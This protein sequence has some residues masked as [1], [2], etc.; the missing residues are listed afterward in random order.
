MK[1][2]INFK[3]WDGET[4]SQKETGEAGWKYMKLGH[5]GDQLL[6]DKEY[7]LLEYQRPI[8]HPELNTVSKLSE[9][10]L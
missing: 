4:R 10:K 9:K 7:P 2:S 1:G 3:K 8:S 6:R 5:Y